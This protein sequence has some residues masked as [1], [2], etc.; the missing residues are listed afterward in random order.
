MICR[1]LTF[2]S[3]NQNHF[4]ALFSL[5]HQLLSSS[6][7]NYNLKWIQFSHTS[8]LLRSKEKIEPAADCH[9]AAA[10]VHSSN[11]HPITQTCFALFRAE[12]NADSEL[13]SI[14][15]TSYPDLAPF[16]IKH[17]ILCF[18]VQNI[19]YQHYAPHHH[20]HSHA[21]AHAHPH[22][23][24]CALV[25][26]SALLLVLPACL[27]VWLSCCYARQ[28]ETAGLWKVVEPRTDWNILAYW[29]HHIQHILHSCSLYH[30]LFCDRNIQNIPDQRHH[31]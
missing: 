28:T 25:P 16:R 6:S 2:L 24:S 12:R 13:C 10:A 5:T 9:S 3:R 27:P 23:V 14:R 15:I 11:H 17:S 31:I 22:A 18:T 1:T 26:S 20:P 19:S 4:L 8:M 7:H 29:K 30:C 21:H